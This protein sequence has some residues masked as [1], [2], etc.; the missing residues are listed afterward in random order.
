MCH[1]RTLFSVDFAAYKLG[2]T[3]TQY[4]DKTVLLLFQMP[5]EIIY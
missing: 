1:H 4:N 3:G 5:L 2:L